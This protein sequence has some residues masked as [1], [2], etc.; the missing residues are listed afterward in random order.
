MQV[1][2]EDTQLRKQVL[3]YNV[4]ISI[5]R[6]ITFFVAQRPSLS[7]PVRLY[8]QDVIINYWTCLNLTGSMSF[9]PGSDTL[10]AVVMKCS[11]F[12]DSLHSLHPV[13]FRDWWFVR[14]HNNKNKPLKL[15]TLVLFDSCYMFRSAYGI[16]FRQSHQIR[17]LLTILGL[18]NNKRPIWWDCPNV[19]RNT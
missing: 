10:T 4:N 2:P 6:L 7:L 18:F 1:Y 5:F 9:D 15:L 16:I 13:V 17:L 3:F 19:D 11:V 14:Q 12:W 8:F